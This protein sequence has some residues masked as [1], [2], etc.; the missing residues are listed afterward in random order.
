MWITREIVILSFFFSAHLEVATAELQ[1]ASNTHSEDVVERKDLGGYPKNYWIESDEDP[2]GDFEQEPLAPGQIEQIRW[3]EDGTVVANNAYVM[4]LPPS[5]REVLLEY[6]ERMGITERFRNLTSRGKALRPGQ[7][8]EVVLNNGL[9]WYIQRPES[10][11]KSNMHWISPNNAESQDDYLKALSAAG[12][13]KVL[14]SV[15][16]KFGMDGL[17]AYHITFIAVSRCT[18]GYL[19]Y[20]VSETDNKVFNVIIPLI[21]AD[22]TGPELDLREDGSIDPDDV[23]KLRYQYDVASMLGDDA[24]HATSA[25]DYRASKEMRMAATIYIADINEENI[26]DI[27]ED[28]TVRAIV[29]KLDLLRLLRH[30]GTILTRI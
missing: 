5:V 13:D 27:L 21:L 15:G 6:C 25:V 26:E 20:D 18:Q 22:E 4:G 19:H 17:A 12:F 23:G 7:E 8:E 24:Y 1:S 2:T 3:K 10:K 30:Q 28:Y 29:A 9:K 14:Q 16:Q 11:W